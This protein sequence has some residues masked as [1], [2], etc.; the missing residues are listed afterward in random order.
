M[1][2]LSERRA[3]GRVSRLN[4]HWR[5]RWSDSPSF[6]EAIALPSGFADEI[7]IGFQSE[8]ERPAGN[9]NGS[10]VHVVEHGGSRV[11]FEEIRAGF[12]MHSRKFDVWDVATSNDFEE[13]R[14]ILGRNSIFFEDRVWHSRR[15][16]EV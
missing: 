16:R 1:T 11:S 12:D 2:A 9:S 3:K 5:R 15:G 14:M 10:A 4:W 13:P 8:T 6:P 7:A